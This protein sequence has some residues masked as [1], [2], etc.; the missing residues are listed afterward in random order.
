[1]KITK[2]DFDSWRDNLVTEQVFHALRSMADRSKQD[3]I[4]KSWGAGIVDPVLLA[5]L[6]ARAET[7]SDLCELTFEEL[8]E[9][10]NEYERSAPDGIQGADRTEEGR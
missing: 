1:M 5:D 4:A 9:E 7:A 8:E 2:E 3:W 10:L 6:R